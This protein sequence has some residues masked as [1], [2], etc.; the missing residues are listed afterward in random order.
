MHEDDVAD[1][2]EQEAVTFL[3]LPQGVMSNAMKDTSLPGSPGWMGDEPSS[4]S[5]TDLSLRCQR[6]SVVMM[7]LVPISCVPR[8]P[9]LWCSS[10]VRYSIRELLPISSPA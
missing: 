6:V 5:I 1:A 9:T 10:P 4:T 3:A 7:P 2:A 8:V